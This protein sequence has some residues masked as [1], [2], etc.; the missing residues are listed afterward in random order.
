M[1]HLVVYAC[2]CSVGS[3]PRHN[4]CGAGCSYVD[5]GFFQEFP[6]GTA[7]TDNTSRTQGYAASLIAS[8]VV[9]EHS[10]FLQSRASAIIMK[11]GSQVALSSCSLYNNVYDLSPENGTN[12]LYSSISDELNVES[13]NTSTQRFKTSSL[14]QARSLPHAR[15]PAF[16]G[17]QK[18]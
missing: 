2:I 18:V 4:V 8:S 10:K 9:W 15:D 14:E 13:W 17:L 1:L 12:T 16:V 6:A 3:I 11:N 5:S 7:V